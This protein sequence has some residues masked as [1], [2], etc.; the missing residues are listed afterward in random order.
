MVSLWCVLPSLPVTFRIHNFTDS[1]NDPTPKRE[2]SADMQSRTPEF[3]VLI[4]HKALC[5][6]AEIS[7]GV[8]FEEACENTRS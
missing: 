3:S 4:K 7:E 8:G 6:I 5:V 2:K 1:L